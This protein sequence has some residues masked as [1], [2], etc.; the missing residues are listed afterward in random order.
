MKKIDE[1][2]LMLKNGFEPDYKGWGWEY[3]NKVR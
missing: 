3:V 1:I 2:R